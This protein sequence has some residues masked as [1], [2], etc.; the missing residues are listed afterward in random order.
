MCSISPNA[1]HTR[2]RNALSGASLRD[3]FIP[4]RVP[5]GLQET[6]PDGLVRS[7]EEDWGG[8]KEGRPLGAGDCLCNP[9]TLHRHHPSTQERVQFETGSTEGYSRHRN[10]AVRRYDRRRLQHQDEPSA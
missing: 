4:S 7:I 6:S 2:G 5:V 1:K 10:E 3:L 9:H 8:V